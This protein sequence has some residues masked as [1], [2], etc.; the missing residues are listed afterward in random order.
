M[1]YSITNC[2]NYI[3]YYT[4]PM[5]YFITGSFYLW[6]FTYFSYPQPLPLATMN[7][8]SSELVFNIPHVSEITHYLSSWLI[9]LRV[10]LSRSIHVFS[11]G[12]ISLLLVAELYSICVYRMTLENHGSNLC[13]STY[14]WMFYNGKYHSVTSSWLNPGIWRKYGYGRSTISYTWIFDWVRVR[15]LNPSHCSRVS[16]TVPHLLCPF[17]H[18]GTLVSKF[19][20]LK[21]ML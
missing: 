19:W 4:I 21:I 14:M 20:L 12:K 13:L 11:N 17:I 10:M 9:S 7:L 15:T 16:C 2:G 6:P 5:V 3:V 18:W 8:F 1:Q